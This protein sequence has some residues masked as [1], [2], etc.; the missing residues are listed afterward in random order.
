MEKIVA[1]ILLCLLFVSG[2]VLAAQVQGSFDNL[3]SFGQ[4]IPKIT[5][6]S[7]DLLHNKIIVSP[8]P[9]PL[10]DSG[11]TTPGVPSTTFKPPRPSPSIVK[12]ALPTARP[13]PTSAPIA[14]NRFTVT[15]LDGSTSRL[16]YS[17]E[18]INRL[19]QLEY[20]RSSAQAFYAFDMRS[21]TRYQEE[22][23][24]SGASIY[25]DAKARSEQ[26]AQ[27]NLAKRDAAVAGMQ[28]IEKQGCGSSN[29][30]CPTC[31]VLCTT[32]ES[33]II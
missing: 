4:F 23:E 19:Q 20:E 12:R 24:R 11:Q 33:T 22:Y 13:L 31:D 3:L 10:Y 29:L 30:K 15:H 28:E 6:L 9:E 5:R 25:L 2:V 14:C 32:W 8:S 27:E 21:A 1:A 16:C 17:R 18:N 26:S 7:Q